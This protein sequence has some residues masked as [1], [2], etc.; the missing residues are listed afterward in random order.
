MQNYNEAVTPME[1]NVKVTN[2]ELEKHVD[3]TLYK[4]IV[5]S[6]IFLCNSRP[7]I[8]FGVGLVSRFM[9]DP[10]ALHMAAAKRILRYLKGTQ[11]LGLL[12]SKGIGQTEAEFEAY[13]NSDCCGDK[14]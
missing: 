1:L 3:S 5:G 7:N 4:Q 12:F 2:G 13:Y 11:N 6:L 9:S 8:N 10:R 14:V